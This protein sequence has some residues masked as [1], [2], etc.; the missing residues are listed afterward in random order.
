RL[1][2]AGGTAVTS[3]L[4]PASQQD[5]LFD[6]LPVFD[7][8][9]TASA[10]NAYG[11]AAQEIVYRLLG[12]RPIPINGSYTTNF[13]GLLDGTY[14]EIKSTRR[15]GGKLVIYDW[16]MEKEQAAGVPLRYLVV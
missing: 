16:R 8:H 3:I 5:R 11:S 2:R 9:N 12:I 7:C 14:Y 4:A 10:R 1:R 13:D 6:L 15:K